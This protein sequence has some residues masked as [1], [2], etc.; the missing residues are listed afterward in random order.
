M[1][2][3][4]DV[5]TLA[6]NCP[7]CGRP[8]DEQQSPLPL[9]DKQRV[10]CPDGNC[11]GILGADEKCGTC[12]KHKAWKDF[13][14]E[15]SVSSAT[16]PETSA[17]TKP[18]KPDSAKGALIAFFIMI[19]CI[20]IVVVFAGIRPEQS[21]VVPTADQTDNGEKMEN[22]SPD[23]KGNPQE[24]PSVFNLQNS[25]A[26]APDPSAQWHY[27]QDEDP[28][29]KDTTLFAQVTS[30]NEVVF[31]S[32]YGGPQHATLTLR[33]HPR[34]G[35]DVILDI[36]RGQFLCRPYE[37]CKVLVRFD[38]QK[39]VTYSGIGPSDHGTTTIFIRNYPRFV[40]SMLKSERVRISAEVYQE[41][42]PV[43]D[44]D[45]SN[46]SEAKYKGE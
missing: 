22:S 46:F 29:G 2:C 16:D 5:S 39:A 30:S 38:D 27:S 23:L 13:A 17:T 3:G 42:S 18:E 43:F 41:G 11:T 15:T 8:V 20:L 44:F 32:P 36:E 9:P 7:N 37:D 24:Y 19:G 25:V 4:K 34:H 21:S 6:T 45:V 12:G 14:K 28:M 10:L 35:K 40:A 26:S 1:D 33:T 31:D